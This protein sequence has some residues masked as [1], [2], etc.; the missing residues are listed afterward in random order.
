MRA[1]DIVAER[2]QIERRAAV[3]GTS[4]VY[5][6]TDRRTGAPVALKVLQSWAGENAARF[7]REAGVLAELSHPGIVRYIWHG[8]TA[9][10]ELYLAMD[11]LEGETLAP[12]PGRGP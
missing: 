12:R 11:W 1:G 9:A 10:G 6:A 3:G 7:A 2:F 8:G 4:A 5:R